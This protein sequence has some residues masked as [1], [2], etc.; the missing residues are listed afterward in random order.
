MCSP[1]LYQFEHNHSPIC[2]AP[3]VS[4]RVQPLVCHPYCVYSSATAHQSH[5]LHLF[6]CQRSPVTPTM[7]FQAQPLIYHPCRIYLSPSACLAVSF[8][9]QPLVYCPHCIYSS[10]STR[11]LAPP[12]LFERN[13]SPNTWHLLA[14]CMHAHNHSPPPRPVM[15]TGSVR[16]HVTHVGH[17]GPI[18]VVTV[19]PTVHVFW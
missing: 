16:A 18:P 1:P 7:S 3:A 2:I 5:P 6:R 4:V 9:A 10:T 12:C 15:G 14:T 19:C 13:H 17:P 11:P 8:Q